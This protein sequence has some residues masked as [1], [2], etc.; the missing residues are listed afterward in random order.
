MHRVYPHGI[1]ENVLDFAV[2]GTLDHLANDAAICR[3]QRLDHAFCLQRVPPQAVKL[4]RTRMR[5]IKLAMPSSAFP[6]QA[7]Y[8][9]T[10]AASA[11]ALR[12]R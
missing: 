2:D 12:H 7:E 1:P 8:R 3:V 5:G 4:V 6:Y 10:H 11:P 9:D